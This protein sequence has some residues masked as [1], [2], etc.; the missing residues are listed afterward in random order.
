MR[1]LA[2]LCA[3]ALLST[4]C[5]TT[6]DRVSAAEIGPPPEQAL[7]EQAAMAY[8]E[9]ALRDPGG[10]IVEIGPPVEKGWYKTLHFAPPKFAWVIRGTVTEANPFGGYVP[11]ENWAFFYLAD[12]IVAAAQPALGGDDRRDLDVARIGPQYRAGDPRFWTVTEI[13]AG[14]HSAVQAGLYKR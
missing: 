1:P 2:P 10:A 9:Q 4:G 7:A 11:R 8:L 14:G 13:G 6:E 5:H 12:E 3:L